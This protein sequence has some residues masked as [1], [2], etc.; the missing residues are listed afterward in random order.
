MLPHRFFQIAPVA[1]HGAE[2]ARG[3]DGFAW[4]DFFKREAGP[5]VEFMHDPFP[6]HRQRLA[7]LTRACLPELERGADTHPAKPC[8]PSF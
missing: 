7:D 3:H 1:D 6:H 5:A 2:T 4:L 8:S